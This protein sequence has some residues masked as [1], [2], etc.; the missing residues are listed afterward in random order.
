MHVPA[1]GDAAIIPT[2]KQVTLDTPATVAR[3][4]LAGTLHGRG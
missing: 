3:L 1:A 2:G 4:E